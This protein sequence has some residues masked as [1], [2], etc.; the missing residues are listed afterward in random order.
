[1][2]CICQTVLAQQTNRVLQHIDQT[3]LLRLHGWKKNFMNI[4]AT[5]E[6][7]LLSSRLVFPTRHQSS[8]F[9]E[10]VGNLNW[11]KVGYP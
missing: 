8:R 5:T 2:I 7:R 9:G 1:L 6:L 11:F 4:L 3:F 10:T